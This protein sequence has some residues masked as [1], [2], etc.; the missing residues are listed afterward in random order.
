ML[1]FDIKQELSICS[2]KKYQVFKFSTS[3]ICSKLDLG[4]FEHTYVIV[5][6]IRFFNFSALVIQKVSKFFNIYIL[7]IHIS[8]VEILKKHDI[9]QQHTHMFKYI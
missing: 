4:A 7:I 9:L 8:N 2:Y 5:K 6:S 3:I 1:F